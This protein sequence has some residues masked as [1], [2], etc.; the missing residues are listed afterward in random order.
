[1]NSSE[2]LA[3][4]VSFPTVSDTENRSL[5]NWV[6]SYLQACG[7][8]VDLIDGEEDGKVALWARLGP[9]T[10]GGI[11]FAGH[12][13][14]VPVEDQPWTKPPFAMTE[15]G[16]KLYGRGTC[17]MKGYIACVLAMLARLDVTKLVKPVY[18]ALTYNEEVNMAGAIQLV[19]WLKERGIK[20]DWVW[21]GEPT[22]LE[23]V[24][25]HKGTG[26]VVTTLY[27][28]SAHS[29]LPHRGLSAIEMAVKV[30]DWLMRKSDYFAT[31]PLIGSP[32]DPPYSTINI[33]QINGGNAPNVIADK[34]SLGWQY[35]LHPGGNLEAFFDDYELMLENEIRPMMKDFPQAR[36][37][38]DIVSRIPPF[39]APEGGIGERFLCSVTG[40][41]VA[42]AVSYATEAGFYQP[43]ADSVVICGPG[44]IAR[45]HQTDEYIAVRDLERCD[46]LLDQAVEAFL[47]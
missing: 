20:A 12:T 21:L 22:E 24:T 35:R 44:S 28:V 27:G 10:E 8:S 31:R 16:G 30:S 15:Q 34:C 36:I 18:L 1:M 3:K 2:I 26:K 7:A 32:F 17:D 45:A 39:M 29:S 42:K 37:V 13:D 25:T 38:T 4:L 23:V 19:G 6:V 47:I 41:G 33:G 43:I 9:A 11:V 46:W 40:S 14:V 5:I